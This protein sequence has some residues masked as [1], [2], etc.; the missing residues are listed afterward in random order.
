[1]TSRACAFANSRNS[2]F[3]RYR[4]ATI[5]TTMAPIPIPTLVICS[6]RLTS[7][8]RGA[9]NATNARSGTIARSSSNR[10]EMIFW[11]IG[12]PMSPRS[13]SSCIT[14][15]V[16]VSTKPVPAISDAASG[17]PRTTPTSD[18]T[19]IATRTCANPRPKMSRRIDQ[20]LAG[21]I[22][23]PMMNRN[24]TTPSSATCRIV[25]GSSNSAR[26]KGPIARPAARYPSTEP[27]PSRLKMGTATTALPSRMTTEA[28]SG[29]C[30]A[31][32]AAMASPLAGLRARLTPCCSRTTRCGPQPSQNRGKTRTRSVRSP[33]RPST[34]AKIISHFAPSGKSMNVPVGMTSGP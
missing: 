31:A 24:I 18:S 17:Y 11:P 22:S 10:I 3:S 29:P 8:A 25:S 27:S 7:S 16:E 23:S 5:N 2:G 14:M 4:P 15:A 9:R 21:S 28:M 30:A 6:A 12:L 33:N 20:S 19:A 1:M 13:A 34:I 32:S 26:P